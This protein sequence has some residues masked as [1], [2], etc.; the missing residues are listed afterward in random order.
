MTRARRDGLSHGL[1]PAA[2]EARTWIEWAAPVGVAL[3]FLACTIQKIWAHDI[4]WQLRTGQWI[5]QNLRWPGGDV[6]SYTA[7]GNEWIE[8]R[9]VY[10]VLC[11]AVWSAGGAALLIL[12]HAAI[13]A[14]G[15]VVLMAPYYRLACS[16][17]GCAVLGLGIAAALPRLVA[18][19]E[20]ATYLLVAVF[21]IVLDATL[22]RGEATARLGRAVWTLPLLQVVWCNTHTMF[23][24]GPVLAWLAAG[25]AAARWVWHGLIHR[26][27]GV[28][29][30]SA[31]ARTTGLLT[32]VALLTTAAC[33]VNP[34]F[35]R[36]ALFPFLLLSEIRE[37]HIFAGSIAEFLGPFSPDVRWTLDT[38]IA[39]LFALVS[40]A[41]FVA[42]GRRLSLFRLT[43]WAAFGYLAI[44]AGRNQTLFA[45][46]MT[47]SALAN[48]DELKP[49]RP[50]ALRTS[51]GS[52][53]RLA[54]STAVALPLL[55]SAWYVASDRYALRHAWPR[56][57]GLGVVAE[58]VPAG[59]VE[60]LRSHRPQG[61]LLHSMNDGAYFTWALADLYPVCIDGRL[62]VYGTAPFNDFLS[63][64][65]GKW[66]E[67]A[68]KNDVNTMVLE[69]E[70]FEPFLVD[71]AAATDWALVYLDPRDAIFVRDV[72][73][74]EALI[75]RSR[76][77]L[78]AG[79]TP[80]PLED[81]RPTGWRRWFGSAERPW[82]HIGLGR[83][84]VALGAP[85]L[86]VPLLDVAI[87]R[88][89]DSAE[90]LLAR[91]DALR[92]LGRFE[93]AVADYGRAAGLDPSD[94]KALFS[95]A[96]A[97]EQAGQ[98]AEAVTTLRRLMARHGETPHRLL[99]LGVSLSAIGDVAEAERVYVRALELDPH[100]AEAAFNLGSLAGQ[101][102]NWTA[103]LGY[104]RRAMEI[105][106]TLPSAVRNVVSCLLQLGRQAE[107]VSL[108]EKLLAEGRGDE[109]EIR[110]LLKRVRGG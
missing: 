92:R 97:Y 107:A 101:R 65:Q 105:R 19:P 90:A 70:F 69:R 40:A 106:P 9:W 12:G 45:L 25:C 14:A 38:W 31:A 53:W 34:Y 7:H 29:A 3:F 73:A 60:F 61:R 6:L 55:L 41:L 8:V 83:G 54:A 1:T 28:S 96:S 82:R 5:V 91:G 100:F 48:L 56:R 57:F 79:W 2:A 102:G 59:A 93:Q 75:S 86:A 23:M 15:F 26:E 47:W 21:L 85:S 103:A 13:L 58:S 37:G 98:H 109:A 16:A 76:I 46:A 71:V 62:E 63:I 95:Q 108:L 99:A 43:V 30:Q 72:P 51:R 74:H 89:P 4:W 84:L 104:F 80:P 87:Q 27:R 42:N 10:C 77:N 94:P 11:Y 22:R 35:H 17:A 67:Y 66:R 68:A 64:V 44:E 50:I 39:A 110:G 33:W 18:R 88:F 49:A 78:A 52:R 32:A 20:A 81:E 24:L 36:G